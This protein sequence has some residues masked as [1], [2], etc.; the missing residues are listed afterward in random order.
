MTPKKVEE[1][2]GLKIDKDSEDSGYNVDSEDEL[3]KSNHIVPGS[4][5]NDNETGKDKEQSVVLGC[6]R[7]GSKRTSSGMSIALVKQMLVHT[8]QL[9]N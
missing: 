2:A 5:K 8:K 9:R 1:P 6:Y 3:P 4:V 7:D